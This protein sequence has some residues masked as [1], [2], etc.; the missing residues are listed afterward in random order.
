[1]TTC[2]SLHRAVHCSM[3]NS[4]SPAIDWGVVGLRQGRF[5]SPP[6]TRWTNED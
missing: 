3:T 5:F 2:A 1:M 4:F 6:R